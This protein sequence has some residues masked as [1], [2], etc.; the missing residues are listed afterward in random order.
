MGKYDDL[1]KRI[2]ERVGG[3]GNITGLTHCATKLRFLLKDETKADTRALKTMPGVITVIQSSGQYQLVI[4][5]HAPAVCET[6]SRLAGIADLRE[7][8]NREKNMPIRF[9]ESFAGIFT[10][11]I[12][13]F[14]AMGILKGMQGFC[15]HT[16]LYD[17]TSGLYQ[18]I[19]LLSDSLFYYLPIFIGATAA[20]KFQLNQF[21]GMLIGACLVYPYR[22]GVVERPYTVL[23]VILSVWAASYIEHFLKRTLPELLKTFLVP[24][25]TLLSILI[26]NRVVI[27]TVYMGLTAIVM[28]ALDWTYTASPFLSAALAG[29]SGRCSFFWGFMENLCRCF[30]NRFR[31]P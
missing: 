18:L 8:R 20:R 12:G 7:E 17:E 15:L 27:E 6:V 5:N 14:C 13:V 26:L 28:T 31:T 21:T 24:L 1:A 29:G 16:G 30:R 19:Q 9:M 4:G 3:R 2:I 23:P 25:L 10:P 11:M 22:Y